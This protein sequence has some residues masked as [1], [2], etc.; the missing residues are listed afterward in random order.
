MTETAAQYIAGIEE[1]FKPAVCPG[2]GI[3]FGHEIEGGKFLSVGSLRL[4]KLSG[5]CSMPLCGEP[6]WWTSSERHLNKIVT[7]KKG[8]SQPPPHRND[9]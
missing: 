2:C 6:I 5:F 4:D 7:R 8:R 9:V 1:D 3:T